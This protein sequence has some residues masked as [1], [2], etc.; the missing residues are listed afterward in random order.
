MRDNNFNMFW[1]LIQKEMMPLLAGLRDV[2]NVW[3]NERQKKPT[4]LMLTT[5]FETHFR[6]MIN[7]LYT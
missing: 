7:K 3:K 5:M 4:Q 2:A 6:D 1:Q